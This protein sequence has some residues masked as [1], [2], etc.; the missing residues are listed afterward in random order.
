MFYG[1]P[2]AD[3]TGRDCIYGHPVTLP[4]D[5]EFWFWIGMMCEIDGVVTVALN[6]FLD[7]ERMRT[8]EDFWA[9]RVRKVKEYEVP[10]SGGFEPLVPWPAS[11]PLQLV[12]SGLPPPP[13]PPQLG[14]PGRAFMGVGGF[15][16]RET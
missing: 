1:T 8:K 3:G 10:G 5:I 14:Q 4:E 11:T 6:L 15:L 16:E 13:P 12:E 9:L 2:R 7:G